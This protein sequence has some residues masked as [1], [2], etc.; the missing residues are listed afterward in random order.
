MNQGRAWAAH[1]AWRPASGCA[2]DACKPFL[3]LVSRL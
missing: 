2:A 1:R 3:L